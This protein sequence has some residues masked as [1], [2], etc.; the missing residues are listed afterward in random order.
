MID[1]EMREILADVTYT[2]RAGVEWQIL[3]RT[4]D[5]GTPYLQLHFEDLRD[6]DFVQVG[7]KWRLSRWM[8]RSEVVW[9]AFAAIHLAEEHELRENF[10]YRGAKI[11]GPHLD[12]DVLAEVARIRGN[13]DVRPDPDD[14]AYA[15]AVQHMLERADDPVTDVTPA[16]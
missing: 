11:G 4:E 6:R 13:I 16:R 3:F 8:T 1:A 12:V 5:D 7:R 10:R 14:A 15:G 9:T 2:D